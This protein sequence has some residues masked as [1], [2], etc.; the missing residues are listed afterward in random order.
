MVMVFQAREKKIEALC[1]FKVYSKF[2]LK[3]LTIRCETKAYNF[4]EKNIVKYCRI[5]II[6]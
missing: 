3:I 5:L 4:P 6:N 2:E 1:L